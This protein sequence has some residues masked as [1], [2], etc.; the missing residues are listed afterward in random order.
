MTSSTSFINFIKKNYVSEILFCLSLF[1]AGVIV[2]GFGVLSPAYISI[3]FVC[4]FILLHITN[5][6]SKYLYHNYPFFFCAAWFFLEFFINPSGNMK[7][8]IFLIITSLSYPVFDLFRNKI[9]PHRLLHY[10]ITY[11][12]FAILLYFFELSV[13]LVRCNF[14]ISS[15]AAPMFF[16]R[17]FYLYKENLIIG[18]G[19]TN[20]VATHLLILFFFSFYLKRRFFLKL[21]REL[22]FLLFFTFSRSSW[23]ALVFG[24]ITLMFI[25]KKNRNAV[26]VPRL[27]VMFAVIISV[28]IVLISVL[29]SDGSFQTKIVIMDFTVDF[30]KNASPRDLCFGLGFLNSIQII[31]FNVAHTL[32]STLIMDT[33]LI[34]LFL[35]FLCWIPV[36]K[37]SRGFGLYILIPVFIFALSFIQQ[38]IPYLYIALA[39]ISN[40]ERKKC[41]P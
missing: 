21:G 12:H 39:V 5:L 33:G 11:I 27:V 23:I 15:L 25:H 41:F 3:I 13:R 28:L 10:S 14:T 30:L 16:V 8:G 2:N 32:I 17:M 18:G 38:M 37:Q 40:L 35:Y 36:L 34:S 20:F 31:K 4:I 26:S 7:T 19:D 1:T 9:K 24:I 6:K 22:A 29:S